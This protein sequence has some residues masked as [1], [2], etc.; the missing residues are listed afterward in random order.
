MSVKSRIITGIAMLLAADARMAPADLPLPAS[1]SANLR[2]HL[3]SDAGITT[4]AGGVA[5]W[6]DQSGNGNNATNAAG[7]EPGFNSSQVLG[8]PAIRFTA[9]S[10]DHFN[11]PSPGSSG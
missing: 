7:K 1:E 2:L 8:K 10:D 4:N 9:A 5:L 6:A 11:L 3:R